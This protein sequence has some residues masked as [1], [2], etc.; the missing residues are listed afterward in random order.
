M[1][2]L[3]KRQNIDLK[4]QNSIKRKGGKMK[5]IVNT[6]EDWK[7]RGEMMPKTKSLTLGG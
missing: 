5:L 1:K 7:F 3:R 2:K 4:K 6:I